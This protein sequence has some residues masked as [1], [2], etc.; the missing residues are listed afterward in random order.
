MGFAGRRIAEGSVWLSVGHLA[1]TAVAFAGSIIIARLLNP[2]EYGLISVALMFPGLLI[3][4]LDFG[5]SEALIRFTPVDEGRGYVSTAFLFKTLM[6]VVT[7][8]VTFILSGYMAQA[9]GRPYVAPMIRILSVYV[10]GEA[11]SGAASQ[12][13]TGA[14]EYN[15]V[16]LLGIV[17]SSVR[18]IA[19]ILLIAMGLGVYG[20]I[21]GFSIASTM[22]LI[23]SLIY[24]SKYLRSARFKAELFKEVIKFSLP[25]YI[26]TILG[27]PLSQVVNI[28]LAEYATNAE[29]GNYSVASNLSVPL[30]IVGGAMA[31][32]IYS[33]LPLLV[34]RKN[35]MHEVVRKSVIYTSIVIIPI[36]M[37]LAVFSKPITY[38]IYGS[39]YSLAP[40]YLSL[41]ALTSLTAVL[42]S[43]VIGSYLNSIGETVK[44]M[45]ISLVNYAI[46]VPLAILL[47]PT[48]R[49][50]GLIT[51]G[52]LAGLISTIY[53]LYILQKDLRLDIVGLRNISVLGALSLPGGLAWLISLTP[54]NI[55]HETL[56]KFTIYM[57]SLIMILPIVI[58]EDE[59]LELIEI[60]KSIKLLNHIVP[61]IL[62]I[63]LVFQ[64]SINHGKKL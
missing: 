17:R 7:S 3:G 29:L 1:S 11:V 24:V 63:I 8:L 43:Y 18:I 37:G 30:G 14:G 25:L 22:T 49:I 2:S 60:A 34:H 53:G 15:K 26:P 6:A 9:L 33:T 46:Y 50:V 51:A 20:S 23:I 64:R 52:I 10:I 41:S 48:Y 4:L 47:I 31:T 45:K 12:V 58:K 19:S 39:Q 32:S 35:K 21:W 62:S 59:V 55:L 56:L 44:T 61:N 42:G 16:G 28:F 36:A 54:M 40:L 13:L 57:V 38:M 27:L 5:I